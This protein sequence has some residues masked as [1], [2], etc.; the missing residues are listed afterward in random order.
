MSVIFRSCIEDWAFG[1]ITNFNV[2]CILNLGALCFVLYEIQV[3]RAA[4][5]H[6]DSDGSNDGSVFQPLPVQVRSS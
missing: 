1:S 5:T 6:G 4:D 2:Y 3:R